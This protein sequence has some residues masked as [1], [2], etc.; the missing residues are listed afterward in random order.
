MKSRNIKVKRET[1]QDDPMP[2]RLLCIALIP[3]NHELNR[4]KYRYQ[5]CGTKISHLLRMDDTKLIGRSEEEL[6]NEIR[7]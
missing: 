1:F 2:Q 3:L 7:L 5:V 4:L 6:R